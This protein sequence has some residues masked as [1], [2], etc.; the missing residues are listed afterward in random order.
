MAKRAMEIAAAGYHNLMLGWSAGSGKVYVSI[1]YF[2]NYA[3]DD[4]RRDDRYYD[5]IQCKRLVKRQVFH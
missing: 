3:T 2:W 5:Y 1:L 4:N